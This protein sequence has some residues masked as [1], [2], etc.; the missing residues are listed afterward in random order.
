MTKIATLSSLVFTFAMVLISSQASAADVLLRV[1]TFNLRYATAADGENSWPNRKD[2]LLKTIR[3]FDPDLLGTQET[4]AVQAD[5]LVENLPGSTLVGV[6]RDDG[7]RQGEFSALL[8]KK[9]RFDLIDSGTFWLSETP[10]KIGSKSWD[11][12]LPRIATWVRL[13]DKGDGGRE[14]C[15][16][17][18]HWDHRGNQ[19]RVESAKIIRRWI[20]EHAPDSL[21]IVTGDL[22][23]TEDHEGYRTLASTSDAPRLRDVFRLLHPQQASA[24]ATFHNFSGKR[25]GRRI[26]FI[27]ASPQATPIEV[28]IDY[29]NRDGRYPSDHFPVTAVLQ[30]DKPAAK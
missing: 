1:M 30:V 29:T 20:S 11:S 26:D 19:A 6:G 24:E 23:I 17:N 16:L 18:T 7:K 15:Y 4:L 10:E 22:N 9:A 3:K 8:F 14:I 21:A 28:G 25:E 2:V 5:F 12:S 27:F 13:R